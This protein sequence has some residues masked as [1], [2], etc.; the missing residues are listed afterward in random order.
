MVRLRTADATG[1]ARSIQSIRWMQV[2]MGQSLSLGLHNGEQAY[3]S[4]RPFLS[5]HAPSPSN[6]RSAHPP[7]STSSDLALPSL[8]HDRPTNH[9][10]CYSRTHKHGHLEVSAAPDVSHKPSPDP[11][12]QKQQQQQQL[13]LLAV[14]VRKSRRTQTQHTEF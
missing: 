12:N 13:L 4:D 5:G 7:R 14:L 10:P 11:C 6:P 2:E 3:M 9:I 8:P 1:S